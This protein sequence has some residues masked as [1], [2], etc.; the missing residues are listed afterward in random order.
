MEVSRAK[1]VLNHER[2]QAVAPYAGSIDMFHLLFPA[3]VL[4]LLQEPVTEW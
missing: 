1:R 3:R 4:A 2:R